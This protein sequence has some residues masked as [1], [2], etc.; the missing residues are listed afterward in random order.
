MEAVEELLKVGFT[1]E[2]TVI[3]AFGFDEEISG[4]QGAKHIALH[5]M[6]RYGEDGVALLIDEGPGI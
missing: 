1:P 4:Y 6:K 5:L 2:R 3:L